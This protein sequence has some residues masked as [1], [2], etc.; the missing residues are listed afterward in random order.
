MHSVKYLENSDGNIRH[1][2]ASYLWGMDCLGKGYQGTV[3]ESLAIPVD[4]GGIHIPSPKQEL[5]A[6]PSKTD[7]QP[8]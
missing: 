6:S 7:Q 8:G 2:I 5:G 4:K 1:M 3:L